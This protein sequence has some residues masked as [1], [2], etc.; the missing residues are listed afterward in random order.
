VD[1]GSSSLPPYEYP[2]SGNR[3]LDVLFMIDDSSSME[4]SQANLLANFTAF[5][6]VLKGMPGGLPDV[7][8]AV[9][10]SDMGAGDGEIAGCAGNGD[11]GVFQFAPRGNCTDTT[12]APGATFIVDTGGDNPRTDFTDPDITN[13]FKCIAQ[14]GASGCGFEHQLASV[15]RALGADGAPAPPENHDFLRP[16]A[17]LAI[18]LL[19]NEDDCSAPVNSVLYDVAVNTTLASQIGPPS[20][21]RCNEFGHLCALPGV[22]PQP[23]GRLSPVP[24][25]LTTTVSYGSC[26]SA[27][28]EGL[29]TPVG[30]DGYAAIA[31]PT[32]PYVVR[33][34]APPLSD[35]GPW[36]FIGHSCGDATNPAGF[37]DPAVRIQQFVSEFAGN[38]LIYP[39]CST[40]YAPAL[41]TIAST[42]ASFVGP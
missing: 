13:V 22:P 4:T 5:M 23:P 39:F 34:N 35:T 26:V 18:V 15:A 11:G 41:T 38:G 31:G 9:V 36:P 1:A 25:D 7:H 37:A 32:T 30:A 20:N 28:G 27:D 29:L 21:F 42:L 10:T 8:I 33:W 6:N 19:T 14:V 40:D 24:S 3:K 17:T 12:L 16:D 2:T